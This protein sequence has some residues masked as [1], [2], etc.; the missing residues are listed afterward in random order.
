MTSISTK[1]RS[2]DHLLNL[3]GTSISRGINATIWIIAIIATT[4]APLASIDAA[5]PPR[6]GLHAWYRD[7]GVL[8]RGPHIQSW[9]NALE[10]PTNR[11][12][13][14]VVGKPQWVRVKTGNALRGIVRLNGSAA[15]WQAV[16]SWGTI[17]GP[18]TIV[19]H[20]RLD[21]M[22]MGVL[23]DGSTRV[24]STP[25]ER[26]GDRWKTIASVSREPIGGQWQTYL[27]TFDDNSTGL[28]GL[29]LGSN[30]ATQQPLRCDLAEVLVYSRKLSSDEIAMIEQHLREKWRDIAELPA[31]EQPQPLT[32]PQ[33][34]RLF[35]TVVRHAGQDNVHTYR[36]PGLA[37]TPRGTLIAV[38]DARNKNGG[39][40]PGDIDVAMM[41]STD[42]GKSWSPLQRII[43]FDADLP[44]TAGNG[45]GDP[46][47]LV[48]QRTGTIFV[49]ALW[50][51]GK[52]AWRDSGP[53]LTADETGQLVIVTSRDDGLTWSA[54]TSITPQVKEREWNLCFNGP[55]SG[56]QL[57]DGTLVFP[58]QFKRKL[59]AESNKP[60][61]IMS[62]S[63]FIASR[64]G[65]ASWKISPAA[66]PRA[67][68][69]SESAIVQTGPRTMLLSMRDESRSGERVWAEWK[70]NGD[71]LWQGA[72][73]PHRQ[74]LPDPTCMA[75][76]V[77]HP[78]GKLIFSNPAH[79]RQRECLTVRVSA[80][81]GRTWNA[82]KVLEPGGAMY[83]CLTI[84]RD[85]QIGILYESAADAG[86][87]FARFPLDW[88]ER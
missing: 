33:D 5:E 31:A 76:V 68:P 80:D 65:G 64:D 29:I 23:L 78:S 86:L 25:V 75:S 84:L 61:G 37:T 36:I 16:G 58:A 50:S 9:E 2:A 17:T 38:F 13:N 81:V 8:A 24:G 7:D 39:D 42:E 44:A 66:I 10:S 28:G 56:I 30:V 82:G 79:A 69:T 87:V 45:V 4:A 41:R 70:W 26:Q 27:F 49:A 72:W 57:D 51:K 55:G 53:G 74:A 15:L 83:S 62:H 11:A 67:M 6:Q 32:R 34:P 88:L 63:C 59:P 54:P 18:R 85:G 60:A 46:A 52:R 20:A 1:P 3:R 19:V 71:D 21:E 22:S 48:D 47:V 77:R 35:T 40:L 14:R 12:L 43:D 73:T